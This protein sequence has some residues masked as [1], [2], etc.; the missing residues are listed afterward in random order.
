[1]RFGK[2]AGEK[3]YVPYYHRAALAGRFD[4]IEARYGQAM[5]LGFFATNEEKK[6][7]SMLRYEGV[8]YLLLDGKGNAKQVRR[9]QYKG[10]PP[11]LWYFVSDGTVVN[12]G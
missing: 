8:V 12:C 1:M 4:I 2:Y 6:E 7:F 11:G 5:M 3:L 10:K 9:R